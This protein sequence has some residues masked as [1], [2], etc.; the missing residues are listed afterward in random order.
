[1]DATFGY[2]VRNHRYREEHGISEVVASRD[3][4]RLC[5]AGLLE[6]VGEK[7]GRYYLAAAPLKEIR[8][9]TRDR[10]RAASPYDLVKAEA[11][12]RQMTLPGMG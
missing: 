4:R 1:M 5:D 11:I 6:P 9:R 7:R 12:A 8:T 2:K 3:L 10:A